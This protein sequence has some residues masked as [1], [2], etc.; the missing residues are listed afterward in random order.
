MLMKLESLRVR[1]KKG[2]RR[3]FE[4]ASERWLGFEEA[5][6]GRVRFEWRGFHATQKWRWFESRESW[7]WF[8]ATEMSNA[9]EKEE[10]WRAFVEEE[11]ERASEAAVERWLGFE[12]AEKWRVCKTW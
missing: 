11:R 3:A 10:R 4:A 1:K 5:E 12:E 7:R 2:L 9:F 8:D 6:R